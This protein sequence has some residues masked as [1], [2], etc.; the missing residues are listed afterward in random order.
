ML[1]VS[2]NVFW[3]M[4]VILNIYKNV[5]EI[6]RLF[7]CFDVLIWSYFLVFRWV[8]I[9]IYSIENIV[10]IVIFKMIIK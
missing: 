9:E 1:I 7:L 4:D 10:M 3:I 2:F 8:I 5:I 6:L